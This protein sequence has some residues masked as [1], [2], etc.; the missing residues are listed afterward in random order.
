[1]Q[2]TALVLSTT[3]RGRAITVDVPSGTR[4]L[5]A[6]ARSSWP[7]GHVIAPDHAWFAFVEPDA[8]GDRQWTADPAL[9]RLYVDAVLGGWEPP[10]RD[11]DVF[12]FGSTPEQAALA[13][14]VIKGTKRASAG[15]VAAAERDGTTIPWPG[16]IS[17]VTDGFGI[18]LC[19]IAT[20]RVDRMRFGDAT[21]EIAIAEGEGDQS[22]DDWRTGHRRYF[23]A[24]GARLGLVFDDDSIVVHEYFK[25]LCVFGGTPDPAMRGAEASTAGSRRD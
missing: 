20:Q 14:C 5:A 17:I 7:L 1:V 16:L 3:H 12:A 21:A 11:F 10:T 24:E 6:L 9:W 8:V 25:L 4:P 19:A 22:L 13:H 15:W 23:E 2:A 18:P